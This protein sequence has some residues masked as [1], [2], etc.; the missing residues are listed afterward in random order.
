MP[1][2]SEILVNRNA[3][4]I[5]EDVTIDATNDAWK[6]IAC[7]NGSSPVLITDRVPNVK[8][9]NS[10]IT[11]ADL[12][13][14]NSYTV[15]S[16][17]YYG[18]AIVAWGTTFKECLDFIDL[19]EYTY[20]EK[21]LEY[22]AFT[23]CIFKEPSVCSFSGEFILLKEVKNVNFKGCRF[24]NNCGSTTTWAIHAS[25]SKFSLR[26]YYSKENEFVGFG[27]GIC[28]NNDPTDDQV[29]VL[30]SG[31]SFKPHTN[32]LWTI[33]NTSPIKLEG[34]LNSKVISNN[35]TIKADQTTYDKIAI[36]L[37]DCKSFELQDNIIEF[38]GIGPI[39]TGI[40]ILN[41]GYQT[42][43]IYNNTIINATIGIIADGAN[44]GQENDP[45]FTNS[46]LKILCNEFV[47]FSNTS[48]YIKATN[49]NNSSLL[50]G[51]S[52]WQQGALN[53]S[54][55]SAI[56]GSPN[57]N[58]TPDRNLGTADNDFYDEHTTI[59]S[60]FDIQYVHPTTPGDYTVRY[61]SKDNGNDLVYT[62]PDNNSSP[63]TSHCESRVPCT[64]PRCAVLITPQTINSYNQSYSTYKT[65]LNGLVNAGDHDYL[66]DLVLE[67]NS[68]NVNDVYSALLN[69]N[70]SHDILAL[71]CGNDVFSVS[72][73]E[74]VLV[75]N[76]YGIKSTSVA[77]A[78]LEREV[79][80]SE[81]QLQNIY[82]AAEKFSE[83][84]NLM[85]QVDAINQDYT[86]LMNR[87][88]TALCSRESI[89][90]DS[91]KLYLE[92]FNDLW[93]NLRLIHIAF[94]EGNLSGAQQRF[95]NLEDISGDES[96]LSDYSTLYDNVL[97]DI[98]TN[99]EGD[100]M[101]MT[102]T[103]K[104]DLYAIYNN[105]TYA[106]SLAKYLLIK[107]DAFEWVL[108]NC[109]QSENSARKAKPVN[110]TSSSS[111]LVTISPNPANSVLYIS[112]NCDLDVTSKIVIFD[113]NGRLIKQ[114]KI[115]SE[116][117]QIS[118]SDLSDGVY[119]VKVFVNNEI[120]THKLVITK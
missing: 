14:S 106:A 111:N 60:T 90:M 56:P 1:Q 93:S 16:N 101:E 84:E 97:L 5:I 114:S 119:F 39:T 18:G 26:K 34:C 67:V 83:Y 8:I 85:M 44:R 58:T 118:L 92:A 46:G 28:A 37:T 27:H 89:P 24:E 31:C 113:L 29:P 68:S 52:K 72:M 87:S 20:Y 19:E 96:E 30:I 21:S 57:F 38:V 59:S 70:P 91:V 82:I 49:C 86:F 11:D 55:G 43:L 32:P 6:G 61:V 15:G 116:K 103:Q 76:S 80:L 109:E 25:D 9:M 107:Y 73:I 45:S 12:A 64:G 3:K 36:N 79:L 71:A 88:I 95:N 102:A 50:Y 13:F 100:F 120:T 110:E 74:E 99:H 115:K 117:D 2:N 65:Q 98:Y 48:Y 81:T 69:S 35:F 108:N 53:N 75:K 41:S 22:C 63:T 17:T 7:N 66:Y 78:I 105:G 112:L 33:Y 40:Y 23:D 10:T 62:T 77:I 54:S 4:L 94:E 104:E 51:V 47:S 42:N